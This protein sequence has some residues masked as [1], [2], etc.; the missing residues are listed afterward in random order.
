M[1]YVAGAA[2]DSE[3]NLRLRCHTELKASSSAFLQLAWAQGA[4]MR[5]SRESSESLEGQLSIA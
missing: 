2:S 5:P 3:R 4:S 1:T